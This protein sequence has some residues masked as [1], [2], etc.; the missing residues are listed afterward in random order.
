MKPPM[1]TPY[2]LFGSLLFLDG[3]GVLEGMAIAFRAPE[4]FPF[5]GLA[6]LGPTL[7]GRIQRYR[8]WLRQSWCFLAGGS[9]TFLVLE[10][11]SLFGYRY[12]QP[13]NSPCIPPQ[14]PPLFALLPS[15]SSPFAT[16]FQ[17]RPVFIS[18][19]ISLALSLSSF[20][21]FSIA[22]C[23]RHARLRRM[24]PVNGC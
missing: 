11:T 18:L 22:L 13:N 3:P 14:S 10:A 2:P 17:L 4:R 6:R 1:A 5:K 16:P 21:S 15:L 9:E 19:S 8:L 20:C 7:S 24:A 12:R 23:T